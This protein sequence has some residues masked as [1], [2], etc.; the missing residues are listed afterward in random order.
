MVN[1]GLVSSSHEL[2]SFWGAN[3]LMK[4]GNVVDAAITTSSV[5]CVVQ[6]NLCGL[7]GDL[8]AL[9]KIGGRLMELNESGRA[10]QAATIDYYKSR[11][12]AEIPK[13]GPLAAPTVPGLV[14]AWGELSRYATMELKELLRPA[15]KYA[16][17]GF[18]LTEKYVTSIQEVASVLGPYNGWNEIFMPGGQVPSP[19]FV[20][21]QRD[22]ARSLKSIAESGTESFY[23]GELAQKI[24]SGIKEQGGLIDSEDLQ[25]HKATWGAPISTDY[26]ETKI[27][28][29]SPNSQAATVLLWLNMLEQYDL[30]KYQLGSE[31]IDEILI[32]TCLKAYEQR[33]RSIADPAFH[34]LPSNFISKEYAHKVLNSEIGNY[35]R[36]EKEP[37]IAGDTTYFAVG[38]ASGNAMSVIQSNFMGFGSGL[39]PKGTGFGLH[40]RGSYFSLNPSHHN[41]LAPGKRTF[42]T[43]CASLA[44]RDGKTLFSLGSMGGDIQPQIHVQL[45]TKILD[46]GMDLQRAIDSPRWIIPFTIYDSPSHI[47]FEG[48]PIQS[49]TKNAKGLN[50]ARFDKL[51]SLA[52][53]AQVVFFSEN[54]LHGAADPR[55]DGA[56]VG[57]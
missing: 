25:N 41:S 38:D 6:N 1:N 55:G 46:F 19:G 18:P 28:E 43:L 29:T 22:L 30:P 53:H 12:L 3:A 40:N 13:R 33:S 48:E 32:D 16:E 57:F 35:M 27:Y 10:A 9:M 50:V 17:D 26:R 5:L 39:F 51:S 49:K 23:N 21:K 8:F 15:I 14:H 31:E 34:P 56:S 42:H 52:G 47:Y 44:E 4:G 20:L 2:A 7:G 37:A 24:I 36:E 54:G 11:G 45:M